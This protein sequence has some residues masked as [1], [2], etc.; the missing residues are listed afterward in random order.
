M[1]EHQAKKGVK[2]K[3]FGVILIFL[4]ALDGMLSWRAGFTL[5]DFYVLLFVSGVF[6]YAVGAIRQESR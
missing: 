4:G 2:T 5:S 6:L 1:E 3:L